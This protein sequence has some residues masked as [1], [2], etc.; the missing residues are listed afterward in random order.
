M[1]GYLRQV[2]HEQ[3]LGAPRDERGAAAVEFALV[4]MLLLTLV[5][6]IAEIGRMWYLQS[7]LAAAARDGART[8]AVENDQDAATDQ[9]EA[10][11]VGGSFTTVS[12]NPG[13]GEC[14]SGADANVTLT[15]TAEFM[16]GFFDPILG[17]SVTLSGK[18]V[19]RCG[20]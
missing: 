6:G 1:A 12:I 9:A 8:M 16:T 5:F 10:V 2:E 18:G 20:G 13:T 3:R 7:S 4:A 17:E 11:F 15:Y 19:M 14:V